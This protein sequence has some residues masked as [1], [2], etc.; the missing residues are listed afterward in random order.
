MRHAAKRRFFP[1]F[2]APRRPQLRF[3]LAGLRRA[4]ALAFEDRG[5]AFKRRLKLGQRREVDKTFRPSIA[6]FALDPLREGTTPVERGLR[7]SLL[8]GRERWAR[9]ALLL[10]T[11]AFKRR[12]LLVLAHIFAF[13]S[14]YVAWSDARLSP[15]ICAARWIMRGDD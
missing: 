8:E 11:G 15:A 6:E 9:H 7:P 2:S 14:L 3:G 13:P 4:S 1:P 5:G 10:S 12:Q